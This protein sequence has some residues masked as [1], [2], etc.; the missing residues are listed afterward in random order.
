MKY[1]YNPEKEHLLVVPLKCSSSFFMRNS[2]LINFMYLNYG[3][4][5]S[6]D[7]F[8]HVKTIA[9]QKTIIWRNPLD[10]VLSSF[11]TF[12]YGI[13]KGDGKQFDMFRSEK[14]SNNFFEDVIYCLP[15]IKLYYKDDFHF[16]PI[17]DYFYKESELIEEYEILHMDSIDKWLYLNFLYKTEDKQNSILNSIDMP[18]QNL[19]HICRHICEIYEELK[20]LY[21][22]DYMIYK[23]LKKL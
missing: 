20:T 11:Y 9:K 7:I 17:I 23:N 4:K 19:S 16:R 10:R 5:F 15:Q 22:E 2:N 21:V 3:N 18:K 8:T 6:H 12:V 13:K 1:F 14:T